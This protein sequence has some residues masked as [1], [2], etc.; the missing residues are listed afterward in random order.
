M[1]RLFIVLGLSLLSGCATLQTGGSGAVFDFAIV[2]DNPYKEASFPRYDRM[3]AEINAQSPAFVIHVGDMKSG[4]S[5]CGDDN[6][7]S[8]RRIH[9]QFTSPFVLTPGDNDWF[10]CSRPSAGGFEPGNR[11][12]AL[13]KLF[14]PN[15][16]S[17]LGAPMPV[18]SQSATP[19]YEAFVENVRFKRGDVHFATVH[20][21][22]VSPKNIKHPA[23][24]E[25]MAAAFAWLDTVFAQANADDANGVFLATHVDVWVQSGMPDLIKLYSRAPRVRT[26]YEAF[27]DALAHHA[28]V[29]PGQILLALG[30]T[31]V[32]RVDKP[33]YHPDTGKL[34]ANFTRVEPFGDD[35]VHWVRVRVDESTSEVFGVHQEFVQANIIDSRTP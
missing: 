30:D 25:V 19:G 2:G 21:V 7:Q 1:S 28:A 17:T 18:I 8:L 26:G 27:N 16:S 10:D 13:R 11:L 32:Y 23:H 9:D 35:E 3:I 12:T 34:L 33:L 22:G 14:Y 29:F 4:G 31:H 5:S 6:F 24:T 20:A 15:P